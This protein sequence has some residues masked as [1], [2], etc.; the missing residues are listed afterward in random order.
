[1]KRIITSIFILLLVV[2]LFVPLCNGTGTG[3][4]SSR[5][6]EEIGRIV[7]EGNIPS[8]HACVVSND[9]I[10]W[11]KGFGAQTAYDTV[12][13]I[14]SIQKTLV[15][16]SILQLFENGSIELDNDVSDYLPFEISNPSYSDVAITI[17]ML[18]AH[19]TGLATLLPHEFCYDWEGAYYP[20]YAYG[21]EYYTPV[22]GLSLG[23]FL[24]ECLTPSGSYYSSSNWLFE[25][26][27]QYSYSNAG[28]KILM[29]LIETVSEQTISD[30][31]QEN[32][33]SPLFMNNTGFNSSDFIG[34]HALP[35][36]RISGS[37]LELP[38]W[39]G[40]HMMRSTVS[41]LGHLMIALMNGGQIGDSQILQPETIDMMLERVS[42]FAS[43]N[44][45]PSEL[46]WEG[47]GLGLDIFSHGLFGHGGSTIGYKGLMYFNPTKMMGYVWLSNVNCI[48]NYNSNDWY[49]IA[50]NTTEIRN[51]VLVDIGLFPA[52]HLNPVLVIVSGVVLA[53][54]LINIFRV[55]RRS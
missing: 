13:L 17:R 3:I 30:Y 36:T 44:T 6:E 8:F 11:V 1:M 34:H 54:F 41:D 42:D 19:R 20:D 26:G 51:L 32:I 2:G 25:P 33:F 38:I 37:N 7:T 35:H 12:F 18:L 46:R 31:M 16:I 15:A 53:I 52:S 21:R 4:V 55:R 47:Y 10:S 28:Y 23:D 22:I 29:Y 14:G 48:L 40:Q 50:R 39:D 27:T 9:E 24:N 49:D 43:E 5:V 45:V